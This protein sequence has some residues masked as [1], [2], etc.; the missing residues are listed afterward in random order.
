MVE[1]S[2]LQ[3]ELKV[4]KDY[5]YNHFGTIILVLSSILLELRLLESLTQYITTPQR[6]GIHPTSYYFIKRVVNTR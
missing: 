1:K 4:E 2:Y 5:L 6:D 3:E